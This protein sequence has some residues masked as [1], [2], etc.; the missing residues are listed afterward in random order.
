MIRALARVFT[1]IMERYLPD[2]FVFAIVL[3]AIVFAAG[4]LGEGRSAASMTRFWGDGLW[5][6]LT[7][8]MQMALILLT[9]FVLA[10]APPVEKALARLARWTPDMPRA[11]VV[12][13][14]VALLASWLNWGF[15]LVVGALLAREIAR[16]HEKMHFPLLVASA[17]S[18]FLVW[19]AG[20]SGSIPLKLATPSADALGRLIPEAIPVSETMFSLPVLIMVLVLAV[21]LPILNMLMIPASEKDWV[22]TMANDVM[23]EIPPETPVTPADKL[24]H[25]PWISSVLVLLGAGYL[26]QYFLDG[27]G[28]TLN[29]INLAFLVLGLALHR[30]PARYLRAVQ[31]AVGSISGIVLQFPLY[32]GIMGMMIH[33]GLA[34]SLSQWFVDISTTETFPLWTFLSAGVVNFFVPSG[35]GQ[36]AVQAPIVVPAAKALGVPLNQAAMAVALG[37][38]WTNMIQPFWAL[39]LLAVARLGIRQIMGYCTVALLWSGVVYGVGLWLLY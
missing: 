32:A 19:H 21:T 14:L 4:M 31:Q 16:R 38:A 2:A 3:T 17:Y 33:S 26:T 25:S 18:G 7:F 34:A 30:T 15:G 9:G 22:N 23:A 35:G 13:T 36:W 12:T 28:L 8:A 39:P 27:G 6:L 24:E 37:D 5:N 20:L 10:T 1:R 29:S 11:V